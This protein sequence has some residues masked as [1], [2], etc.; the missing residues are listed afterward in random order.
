MQCPNC[1]LPLKGAMQFCPRCGVPLP[2]QPPRPQPESDQFSSRSAEVGYEAYRA[3]TAALWTFFGVYFLMLLAQSLTLTLM[4]ESCGIAFS[5]VWPSLIKP[6]MMLLLL[7]AVLQFVFALFFRG[8][9]WAIASLAVTGGMCVAGVAFLMRAAAASQTYIYADSAL[10]TR[11]SR[12]ACVFLLGI[13]IPLFQGALS[14][15]RASYKSTALRSLLVEVVF[16]GLSL[17][18]LYLGCAHLALGIRGVMAACL[19]PLAALAVSLAV[20]RRV[21]FADSQPPQV[22]NPP[23]APHFT[24]PTRNP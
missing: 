22:P 20:N 10:F 11:E 21:F 6:T 7:E 23:T 16:L 4:G 3:F 1:K 17:G 14:F 2:P 19:G 18:G 9:N 13:G 24:P 12:I 8:Q 5:Q 15:C